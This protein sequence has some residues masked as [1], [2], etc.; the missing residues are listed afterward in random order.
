MVAVTFAAVA[1]RRFSAIHFWV[2][3]LSCEG[4]LTA[5]SA[6]FARPD[7]LTPLGLVY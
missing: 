1:A 5:T 4:T 6:A 2:F 7:D 3:R